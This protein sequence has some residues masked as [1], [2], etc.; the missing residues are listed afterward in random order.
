MQYASDFYTVSSN[1][2]LMKGFLI[3]KDF[4]IILLLFKNIIQIWKYGWKSVP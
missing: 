3:I 1:I 4:K 2:W